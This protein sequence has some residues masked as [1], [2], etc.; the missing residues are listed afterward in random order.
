MTYKVIP[1]NNYRN[2][3]WIPTRTVSFQILITN[4][5]PKIAHIF[6]NQLQAPP[7]RCHRKLVVNINP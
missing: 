5:I 3:C 4:P 2:Q 6:P 7:I 1:K